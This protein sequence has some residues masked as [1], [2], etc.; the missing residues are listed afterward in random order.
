MFRCDDPD[1]FKFNSNSAICEF[2]C[3]GEGRYASELDCQKFYECYRSGLTLKMREQNCAK[4]FIYEQKT[5]KCVRGKCTPPDD[6]L[7]ATSD[8]P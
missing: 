8:S 6:G 2:E 4:G 5:Q 1:N 3:Q 7:D